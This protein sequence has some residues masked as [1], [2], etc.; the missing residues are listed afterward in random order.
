MSSNDYYLTAIDN[1]GKMT[2]AVFDFDAEKSEF[3]TAQT[4]VL[5]GLPS[6]VYAY[7]TFNDVVITRFNEIAVSPSDPK[8]NSID[9]GE[10]SS[11]ISCIIPTESSNGDILNPKKL[12]YTVWVEKD[13]QQ[14]P[15][16]WKADMYYG[17]D[18]DATE[19]PWSFNYSSWDGT[20]NIYFQD[21]VEECNTWTKV[22][23][24]SVY[25][26][27]GE[28]NKSAVDWIENPNASGISDI[29]A[30]AEAGKCVIYN[31]AGQRMDAPRKGLNIINGRKVMVK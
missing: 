25:Y 16:I 1:D 30:D 11:G 13:G 18:E 23:I 9:F 24:Q 14:A 6:E 15:Y 4:L 26:G 3:A 10:W 5:N 22:G 19:M 20:H 27:G 7:Q 2:D 21:G 12:F 28:C 29:A 8:I 31:I 17:V